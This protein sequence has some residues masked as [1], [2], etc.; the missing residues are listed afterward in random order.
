[1]HKHDI[2]F[3]PRKIKQAQ[4]LADFVVENNLL[5]TLNENSARISLDPRKAYNL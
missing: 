2:D 3:Q 5:S 1:M 4:L